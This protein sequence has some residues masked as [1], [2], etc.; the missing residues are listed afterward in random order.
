MSTQDPVVMS[1]FE[2]PSLGALRP[3]LGRK[4]VI[5]KSWLW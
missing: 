1:A 4:A 2:K 5:A 3:T